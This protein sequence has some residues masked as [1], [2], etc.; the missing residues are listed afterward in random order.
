MHGVEAALHVLVGDVGSV[1]R[2]KVIRVYCDVVDVVRDVIVVVTVVDS[3]VDLAW[4]SL[5]CPFELVYGL[6][7]F[8]NFLVN[9]RGCMQVEI[10]RRT[11]IP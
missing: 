3:C 6:F 9:A 11:K 7:H 1:F 5:L 4:S 2:P 10:L 8:E